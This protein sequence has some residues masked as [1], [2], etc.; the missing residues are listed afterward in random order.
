MGLVLDVKKSR[1]KNQEILKKDETFLA[2]CALEEVDG[3]VS[4]G[5]RTSSG[6]GLVPHREVAVLLLGLPPSIRSA[7]Q[8]VIF[9]GTSKAQHL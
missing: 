6:R 9:D 3:N 4:R 5:I 2:D 7:M 1:T 8:P